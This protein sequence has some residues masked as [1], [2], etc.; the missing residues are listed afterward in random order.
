MFIRSLWIVHCTL[1]M[2]TWIY[3]IFLQGAAWHPVRECLFLVVYYCF[4]LSR[5]FVWCFFF[6]TYKNVMFYQRRETQQYFPVPS[7]S[8]HNINVT[9][10]FAIH[11]NSTLWYSET[12]WRKSFSE[13]RI[14]ERCMTC[15]HMS[16]LEPYTL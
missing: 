14:Y 2:H 6:R 11:L 3:F 8:V 9:V 16:K 15:I 7:V 1:Y 10:A 12:V 5:V 13:N 4:W